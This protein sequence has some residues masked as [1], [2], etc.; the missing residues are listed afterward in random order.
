MHP[1]LDLKLLKIHYSMNLIPTL[2]SSMWSHQPWWWGQTRSL[3]HW[4][5]TQL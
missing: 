2:R 4:F 3:N 5:M 1:V